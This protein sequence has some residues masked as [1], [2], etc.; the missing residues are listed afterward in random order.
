M[1]ANPS[2]PRESRSFLMARARWPRCSREKWTRKR[3]REGVALIEAG[4]KQVY[5]NRKR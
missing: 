4:E 2:T 5:E 3:E 1:R